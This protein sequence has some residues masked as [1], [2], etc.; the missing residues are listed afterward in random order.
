MADKKRQWL[1]MRG[2]LAAA[3]V[4]KKPLSAPLCTRSN[5]QPQVDTWC[6]TKRAALRQQMIMTGIERVILLVI[7]K[8]KFLCLRLGERMIFSLDARSMH[9]A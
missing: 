1:L 6:L 4:C 2:N 8:R 3:L 5:G 9:I 7:P